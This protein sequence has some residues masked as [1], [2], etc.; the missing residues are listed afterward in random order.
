MDNS[1]NPNASIIP[2]PYVYIKLW[3]L[4]TGT[5]SLFIFQSIFS[6]PDIRHPPW[7]HV[8]HMQVICLIFEVQLETHLNMYSTLFIWIY[9]KWSLQ[10]LRKKV[11]VKEWV[12]VWW[13]LNLCL[14]LKRGKKNDQNYWHQWMKVY[15]YLRKRTNTA[16]I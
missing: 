10:P 6:I 5:A 16:E 13:N 7:C 9:L 12:T 11:E 8:M 15:P 2:G 14:L 3:Q 4:P 1:S